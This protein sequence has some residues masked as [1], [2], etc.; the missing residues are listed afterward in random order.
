MHGYSYAMEH[1]LTIFL[2]HTG[3]YGQTDICELANMCR[4]TAIEPRL[5]MISFSVNACQY[6]FYDSYCIQI[7]VCSVGMP[8]NKNTAFRLIFWEL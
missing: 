8:L 6:C 1:S 4:L 2:G 5:G 3:I 7:Y